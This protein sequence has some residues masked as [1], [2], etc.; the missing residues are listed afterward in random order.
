MWKNWG[1][2]IKN[3]NEE[4]QKEWQSRK[5]REELKMANRLMERRKQRVKID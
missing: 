1:E 3:K 5:E 4:S 2:G